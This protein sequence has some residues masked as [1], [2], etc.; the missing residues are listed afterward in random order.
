MSAPVQGRAPTLRVVDDPSQIQVGALIPAHAL[1]SLRP[2]VPLVEGLM[3]LGHVGAIVGEYGT[4]KTFAALDL[5]GAVALGLKWL[6]ATCMQGLVVII[7]SDSPPSSLV[8]RL[9]ALEARHPG[10]LS[11][12]RLHFLCE[13][14]LLAD[15]AQSLLTRIRDLQDHTGEMVR[16]V[17]VD[18]VTVTMADVSGA[19]GGMDA[20]KGWVR[21]ARILAETDKRAV[22]GIAHNGKDVSRGILGSVA[23]PAGLDFVLAL[24]PGPGGETVVSTDRR[25]G[26]K[27]RD[28]S[29]CQA[30]FR[31]V[32]VRDSAV[33]EMVEAFHGDV[34][35]GGA[36]KRAPGTAAGHLLSVAKTMAPGATGRR[37]APNQEWPLMDRDALR[38]A[39]ATS[40][41]AA[42]PTART[43]PDIFQRQL[44]SLMDSG[45][46]GLELGG[47]YVA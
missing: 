46:L 47:V 23:L 40:V 24:R 34:V 4:G 15:A 11:S 9:L 13:P 22:V 42:K 5:A 7:E 26:G 33:I 35:E 32:P 29:A 17:I 6:G 38:E 12:Q 20:A 16:L 1:L 45:W 37:A 21:G 2:P 31:L 30:S 19:L 36:K 43:T 8:P 10:I 18:S 25:S 14:I 41:R 44:T 27:A 39:W 3:A 28:W